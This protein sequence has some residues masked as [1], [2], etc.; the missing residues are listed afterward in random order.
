MADMVQKNGRAIG[1]NGFG[2]IGKLTLWYQVGAKK[3]DNIVLNIGR[4]VGRGLE[5]IAH[6]ISTDSTYGTLSKFQ[7]FP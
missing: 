4:E 2:R 1:I 6:Y 3:F 7:L 5:D